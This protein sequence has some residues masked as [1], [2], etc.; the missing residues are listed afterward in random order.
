MIKVYHDEAGNIL[1]TLSGDV[2]PDGDFIEVEHLPEGDIAGFRIED[3]E[4][5]PREDY[6]EIKL[7][8]LRENTSLD[9]SELLIRLMMAGILSPEEASAASRGLIPE[10]FEDFITGLDPQTRAVAEVKWGADNE[11]ERLN[12]L[13]V[14][15]AFSKD[16]PDSV[17]DDIFGIE[18]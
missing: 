8:E 13:I 17:V 4:I 9:K 12:P 11:I 10:S 2:T 16:I 1:Y 18:L 6:A 5:V 3:G 15:A 7:A 14:M